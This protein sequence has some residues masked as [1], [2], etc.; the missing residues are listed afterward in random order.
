[1]KLW[2]EVGGGDSGG[3]GVYTAMEYIIKKT[4]DGFNRFRLH[5]YL[6]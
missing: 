6:Y 5:S 1:M 2:K 4:T 3:G